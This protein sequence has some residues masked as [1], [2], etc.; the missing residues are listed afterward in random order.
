MCKMG[1][2]SF[3]LHSVA[4]G[5]ACGITKGLFLMLFAWS[6]MHWGY[7]LTLIT[8]IS[9]VYPGY[10]ASFLGGL[11]GAGYGLLVGFVFGFLVGLFYNLCA[12]CCCSR[13]SCCMAKTCSC[14]KEGCTCNKEKCACNKEGCTC[15]KEGCCSST[16]KM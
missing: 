16:N 2:S 7:G 5:V 12:C 4:L 1:C 3:K 15:N 8:E 13:R 6:A 11:Y 14:T 10:D 9:G